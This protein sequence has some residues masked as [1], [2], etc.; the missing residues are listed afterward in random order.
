[1]LKEVFTNIYQS[2]FWT[3]RCG[4]GST[5]AY[6]RQL[7][8]K[9]QDVIDRYRV[10]TLLDAPCGLYRWIDQVRV[11]TYMGADIVQEICAEN[12]EKAPEKLFFC[13]DLTKDQLPLADLWLCRACL[14]HLSHEN[15]EK[16]LE[17]FHRSLIPLALFTTQDEH[18]EQGLDGDYRPLDMTRYLGPP[19]EIFDDG[20][21]MK[22]GL[23]SR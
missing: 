21:D 23:W 12:A 2:N 20:P 15:I 6:T 7:I 11:E 22:M 16:V 1:M 4:S 10:K 3:D 14:Y 18:K 13:L 19:I 8:P 5:E 17:N 9:L